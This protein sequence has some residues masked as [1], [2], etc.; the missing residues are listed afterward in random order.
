MAAVSAE[1]D[2]LSASLTSERAALRDRDT[3]LASSSSEKDSIIASLS[4]ERHELI[5]SLSREKDALSATEE[6]CEELRD[7][8]IGLMK[9]KDEAEERAERTQ[10]RAGRDA[11]AAKT[12][13]LALQGE[14][15]IPVSPHL[16]QHRIVK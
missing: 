11:E 6:E 2:A 4:D 7:Q 12:G 5:E 9:A 16:W 14:V 8:I 1:R 10:E 3:L 13:L 15:P